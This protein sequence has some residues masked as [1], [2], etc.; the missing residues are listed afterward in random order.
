MGEEKF[1]NKWK[2]QTD[3]GKYFGLSAIAVGKILIEHGLKNKATKLATEKAI[4]Q[5]YAV[6]KALKDG[7][8][9]FMWNFKKMQTHNRE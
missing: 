2:S 6:E 3:I 9:F 5:Y 1:R 4:K 8:I 7:T